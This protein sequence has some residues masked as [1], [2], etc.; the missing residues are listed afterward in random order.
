MNEKFNK[1][2]FWSSGIATLLGGFPMMV[3]P[4]KATKL[5]LGIDLSSQPD[6][7]PLVAHWGIMVSG[8]GIFLCVAAAAVTLRKAAIR[9]AIV[10]KLYMLLV[11][12]YFMFKNPAVSNH[13]L[14]IFGVETLII[15]GALFYFNLNK[16]S[17]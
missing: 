12:T 16:K 6:I 5:M 17:K 3:M 15:I 1:F 14:L 8:L 7:I 13:Y 2:Y 11:L 9:Y 4:E 10:S